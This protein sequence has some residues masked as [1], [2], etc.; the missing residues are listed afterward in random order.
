MGNDRESGQDE[1]PVPRDGP[2]PPAAPAVE[3]PTGRRWLT[4]PA[5]PTSDTVGTGS[6]F[7]LTCSLLTVLAIGLG[8]A[9]WALLRAL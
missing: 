8:L 9:V 2:V 1:P 4:P 6:A 5:D 3:R 7:A